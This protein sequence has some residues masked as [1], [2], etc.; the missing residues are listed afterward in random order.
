M[1][2]FKYNEDRYV[3]ELTDYIANTYK[4]HYVGSNNIQALDLIFAAGHGHGFCTGN[5]LKYAPRYGKKK[6][7]NRDDLMKTLHYA[8]LMLHVHD[9]EHAESIEEP[10]V[11]RPT[12]NNVF[13]PTTSGSFVV[14]D[15]VK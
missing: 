1:S 9:T 12:S 4:G 5:I 10:R 8:L 14:A 2:D 13:K 3:K 7:F 6:G 15:S 11:F